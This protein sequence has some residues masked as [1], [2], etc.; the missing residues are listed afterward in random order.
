MTAVPAALAV[1]VTD[2]VI[3][4]PS[5]CTLLRSMALDT[6]EPN[7]WIEKMPEVYLL[8]LRESNDS[9]T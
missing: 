4:A 7:S 5:S 2:L 9:L 3:F 1:A 8:L 6:P